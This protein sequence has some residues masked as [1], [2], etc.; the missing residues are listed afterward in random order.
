MEITPQEFIEVQRK[1][2]RDAVAS[3][4][5]VKGLAPI[6]CGVRGHVWID[7]S[8]CTVHGQ[9]TM[10]LAGHTSTLRLRSNPLEAVASDEEPFRQA[11][12]EIRAHIA[13]EVEKVFY[14]FMQTL[15][16][17]FVVAR[18]VKP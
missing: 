10:N 18:K 5:E 8:D 17:R 16:R 3:V 6:E 7:E 11:V 15:A 9:L 1:A 14:D 2:A 4:T 13:G 12:E